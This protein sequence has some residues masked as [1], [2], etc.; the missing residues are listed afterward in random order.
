MRDSYIWTRVHIFFTG[1][2]HTWGGV[3][4]PPVKKY[5]P[6]WIR[7]TTI[8]TNAQIFPSVYKFLT[9]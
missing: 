8:D 1:G 4:V 3:C 2:T 5:G 7:G 9:F 6:V